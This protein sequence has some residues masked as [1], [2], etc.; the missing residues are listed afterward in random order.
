MKKIS[1]LNLAA[2]TGGTALVVMGVLFMNDGTLSSFINGDTQNSAAVAKT[3]QTILAINASPSLVE[4][5][6]SA[7]LVW[8]TVGFQSC[9]LT[10]P[11]I[12]STQRKGTLSTGSLTT[13]STYI[14]TCMTK[15][16]VSA[17]QSVTVGI[18]PTAGRVR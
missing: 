1:M 7:T 2:I 5:G 3:D 8:S 16:G 4:S 9:S 6:G 18:T 12:S 13:A 17:S 14:I 15:A 10:G 11:G